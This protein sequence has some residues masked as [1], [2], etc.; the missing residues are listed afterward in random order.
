MGAE[1]A[2]SAA[3]SGDSGSGAEAAAAA[4]DTAVEDEGEKG[5]SGTATAT[6]EAW[7]VWRLLVPGIPSLR[8]VGVQDDSVFHQGHPLQ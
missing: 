3:G 5:S 7:R 4:T 6:V 8:P 2:R 1:A